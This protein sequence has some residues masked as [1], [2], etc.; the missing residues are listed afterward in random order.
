QA[1]D[2]ER[3]RTRKSRRRHET[4]NSAERLKCFLHL[5]LIFFSST[6][7]ALL[8]SQFCFVTRSIFVSP[9]TMQEIDYLGKRVFRWERGASSFLAWPEGG[10]RLMNWNVAYADGSY[11]DVIHW[12]DQL[13]TLDTIGKIRGGNP[14]LF[15]FCGRSFD[16]G[17]IGF[18]K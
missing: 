15:P 3:F 16:E 2:K 4:G 11:R 18:W 12:P 17:E 5:F 8:R 7:F 10:A 9:S 14:I 6:R 13:E 1:I